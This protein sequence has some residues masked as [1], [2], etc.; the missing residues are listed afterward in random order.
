MCAMFWESP[1]GKIKKTILSPGTPENKPVEGTECKLEITN[2]SEDLSQYSSIT[3]G[4][5]D[6]DLGRQFEICVTTMFPGEVSK[7]QIKLDRVVSFTLKL[8]KMEFNGFLFEWN[9]RKKCDYANF[10]K[11]KGKVHFSEGNLR[12]A[13]FRFNKGLKIALSI[14]INCEEPPDEIDGV[15][16]EEINQVKATLYNNLASCFFKKEQ[17]LLVIDYCDKVFVYDKDNIKGCYKAAVAYIKDRNFEKADEYLKKVLEREP[18][19]KAAIVHHEFVK[20]KLKEAE[21]KS[22]LLAKKMIGDIL[23][24]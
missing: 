18:H 11:E 10:Q 14:P 1:D 22:N 3:I 21:E 2:V 24:V 15:S 12:E 23:H 5:V 19:N 16:I 20:I 6:S 13:G 8:S 9:A 4:D 7:F 17:W